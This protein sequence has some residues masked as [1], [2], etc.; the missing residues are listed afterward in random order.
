M[1]KASIKPLMPENRQPSAA[2]K[3]ILAIILSL[4]P[5]GRFCTIFVIYA[6][7]SLSFQVVTCRSWKKEEERKKTE[8]SWGKKYAAT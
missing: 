8:R 2:K 7:S 4:R 5:H 3:V 6:T 1:E